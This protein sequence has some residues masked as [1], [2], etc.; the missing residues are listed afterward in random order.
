MGCDNL[1]LAHLLRRA[2]FTAN[3]QEL[4]TYQAIGYESTVEKLLNPISTDYLPDDIIRRYHVDQSE[5]REL[6]GAASY[7]MYRMITTNSPLE[8]KIALFW[9]S[10][11]ATGYSKLNQ[12]RSLLNQIDMFREYGLGK[13]DEILVQLSKDPAMLV[14]LDNQDNHKG[15]INENYGRELL[16]LF[17]L[18]IGA[19]T[20]DDIK[21]C[22]RAFTGWTLG[23]A[24]YM[25][26]RATKDS[27]WPYG[28]IAWHFAYKD[29]DHD[30]AVKEFLGEKG[31]F[32]GEEIVN[33]I[34]KNRDAAKFI[35]SRLFQ[36]FAADEID[37]E[38]KRKVVDEMVEEYFKSNHEIRAVLRCLFN[39]EYFKSSQCRYDRVKGPVELVV[40]AIKIAGSYNSPTLDI[41][42][43][44]KICFFMGQ[45]FLQPP[46]VEGWHEG[47]EWIDS[48]AL[49]ER[50][51][52]VVRE[53]GN[54]NNPGIRYIL[55]CLKQSNEDSLTPEQL[56]DSCLDLVGPIEVSDQTRKVLIQHVAND[57][58]ID[59]SN[60]K[61]ESK[62]DKRVGEL[63]SLIGASPEFQM[64]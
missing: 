8:E 5:L 11:F 3:R 2:G 49:V 22:A 25:S 30:G 12:A 53:L 34:C 33:I 48:G 40:G 57:G 27:I 51:N 10:L 61:N 36:F 54:T 14:W 59:L 4:E 44:A 45:G 46:T 18:G 52:F 32:D 35:C 56:L 7:W 58:D 62:N 24:D 1:E 26:M 23:N 60:E 15:A 9:H 55:D 29:D 37:D 39:S 17:S 64:A 41:E 42:E 63:L 50:I 16:E 47:V 31:Q 38:P 20:E 43:V 19:Y 21:E 6:F 13:F 28:R